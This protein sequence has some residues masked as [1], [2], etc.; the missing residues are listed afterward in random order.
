MIIKYKTFNPQTLFS[1]GLILAIQA[2]TLL[3]AQTD[4]GDSTPEISISIEDGEVQ[5][6]VN[7][8]EPFRWENTKFESIKTFPMRGGSRMPHTIRLDENNNVNWSQTDI[9]FSGTYKIQQSSATD[10]LDQYTEINGD[11]GI[12]T[13]SIDKN[14][15]LKSFSELTSSYEILTPEEFAAKYELDFYSNKYSIEAL[16]SGYL[17][18]IIGVFNPETNLLSFD[19]FDYVPFFIVPKLVVEESKDMK[20]WSNVKLSEPL[21]KEY[22]RAQELS[23]VLEAKLKNAVFYRVKILK[24]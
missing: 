10:I 13:W 11:I 12:R 5:I 2:P 15:N 21:P 1:L 16:I 17:V 24:E 6:A 19:T 4:E 14:N 23:I 22:Q 3:L 18:K 9:V 8:N 7:L 20:K